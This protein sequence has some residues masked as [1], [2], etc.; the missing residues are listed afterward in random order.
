MLARLK[1]TFHPT[2]K[3]RELSFS[4]LEEM[5]KDRKFFNLLVSYSCRKG[6]GGIIP[7]ESDNLDVHS[8]TIKDHLLHGDEMKIS[9]WGDVPLL[10]DNEVLEINGKKLAEFK[11]VV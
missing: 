10:Y 5:L 11:L 1:E 8:P 7:V 2:P 9:F 3:L 4:S 6:G